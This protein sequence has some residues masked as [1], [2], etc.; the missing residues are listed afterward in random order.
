MESTENKGDK[1]KEP[2]SPAE[3]PNPPQDI[4]PSRFPQ[5]DNNNLTDEKK[6]KLT[7]KGSGASADKKTKPK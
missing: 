7:S 2:F 4:H 1:I 6:K 5:K 3:T